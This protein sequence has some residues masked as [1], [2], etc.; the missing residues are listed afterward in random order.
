ME[1]AEHVQAT[2]HEIAALV[3]ALGAGPLDVAVPTCP[4]WTLADLAD[5]VG[6]FA[7]FWAHVLCEATDRPNTPFSDRPAGTDGPDG[8][9]WFRSLGDDLL[10][11]LQAIEPGQ[12]A[13]TWAPGR[14]NAAFIARR[15]AHELAVHR[16][17]AQSAR[18]PASP[19]DGPLAIDGIDEIFVLR[20]AYAASGQ[21]EVA[22]G[23]GETIHLHA[24]DRE[25]EWL[26]ELTG[27]GLAVRREHAKGDVALRGAVSDLELILYDRPPL[28][29]IE[30]FGDES[31]LGAWYRAFHFG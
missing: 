29:P 26:I 10:T 5:H 18:G 3:E 7:G 20:E 6:G 12:P 8:A 30:R 21:G 4:E 14:Q 17:D 31:V 19:I 27:E 9:A 28:G 13:W 2:E 15:S 16:Y 25:A 11:L 24:T 22:A 23:S 1:Y